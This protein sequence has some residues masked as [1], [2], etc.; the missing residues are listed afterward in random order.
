MFNRII[1]FIIGLG[2][3]WAGLALVNI[4]QP[5]DPPP[6][7][8]EFTGVVL[9]LLLSGWVGAYIAGNTKD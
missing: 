7:S 1:G 3:M 8:L 6:G 9:L 4:E 5:F 2:I